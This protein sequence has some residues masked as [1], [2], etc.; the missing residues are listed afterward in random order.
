MILFQL[1]G[2]EDIDSLGCREHLHHLLDQSEMPFWNDVSTSLLFQRCGLT[3]FHLGVA[4]LHKLYPRSAYTM[5]IS[6]VG[7]HTRLVSL[8][9]CVQDFSSTTFRLPGVSPQVYP[10]PIGKFS[11]H[12]DSLEAL[13]ETSKTFGPSIGLA[14]S[15]PL[16]FQHDMWSGAEHTNIDICPRGSFSLMKG[17]LKASARTCVRGRVDVDGDATNQGRPAEQQK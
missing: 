1:A 12:H 15:A 9:H 7:T 13:K 11:G 6:Q 16:L 17:V 3:I 10:N 4:F 5:I 8:S 2:S 14:P